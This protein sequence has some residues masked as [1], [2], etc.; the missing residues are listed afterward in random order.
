MQH[1]ALL[2]N[3]TDHMDHGHDKGS[4]GSYTSITITGE[5]SGGLAYYKSGYNGQFLTPDQYST[6]ARLTW[7]VGESPGALNGGI[8]Y[9]SYTG[10]CSCTGCCIL[11]ACWVHLL[12]MYQS[13]M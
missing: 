5:F 9:Y 8:R 4:F 2:G 13:Y 3:M 7:I 11:L 6:V 12:H 10:I 1:N